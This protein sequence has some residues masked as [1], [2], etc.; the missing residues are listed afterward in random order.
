MYSVFLV[1]DEIVTR[2]GIRNSIPWKTTPYILA[3][4]APD[5]EIALPALRDI[6]PDILITDIKMP[7][8]DGL[9]LAR[10]IKRDQPWIK[11]II[12]SGHDEFEYAKEAISIGVEEY[13]LKP[14]SARD[15]LA[16]LEKVTREIEK[17]KT[18]ISGIENLK[19][20]IKSSEDIMREK[21]LSDLITGQIPAIHAIETA[22]SFGIDLIA[23]GYIIIV[24]EIFIPSEDYTQFAFVKEII[25]NV[26]KGREDFIL[27]PQSMD[28]LVILGKNISED[29]MDDIIYTLAQGLKFETERNTACSLAIGIGSVAEHIEEIIHSYADADK[30]IRYMHFTG[31]KN[32]ISAGDMKWSKAAGP[33]SAESD[34]ITEQIRFAADNDIPD[35][36]SRYL[37]ITG[38]NS[39]YFS[40]V[41]RDIVDS[42][43]RLIGEFQGNPRDI[44]PEAYEEH[45]STE[46]VRTIIERWIDYRDSH[47]HTRHHQKI[48]EAKEYINNN[49]A[50]QDMSLNDVASHAH[51]SPNHFSTIFSQEAGVTFIEYLTSVRI[52]KARQLLLR[53]NMKC[54]DIAFEVGYNDPHY[55]SYIFKKNCGMSPREFRSSE[56][57]KLH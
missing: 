19:Q 2:E 23:S 7:F 48:R 22:Q 8:M 27:V 30:A 32:I 20:R 5:G 55:F 13:L 35:I 12:L 29:S 45:C 52:N 33:F 17:E 57:M 31:K 36:L 47:I 9:A 37:E 42:V 53:N 16:S 18:R 3:G 11:I 24:V 4:E 56:K 46:A 1:E 39:A 38:G 25:G 10:I 15:M 49:F 34:N 14:V 51:V 44:V 43:C 54:V 26:L 40:I 50:R 28:K 41:Y 6:K 21:W